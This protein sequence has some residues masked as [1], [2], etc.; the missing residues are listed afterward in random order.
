MSNA[1]N[2]SWLTLFLSLSIFFSLL[3][4]FFNLH[5]HFLTLLGLSV[6]LCLFHFLSISQMLPSSTSS[7]VRPHRTLRSCV[8]LAPMSCLCAR[9]MPPLRL[10]HLLL[11]ADLYLPYLLSRTPTPC[12]TQGPSPVSKACLFLSLPRAR[13]GLPLHVFP[14]HSHSRPHC[15]VTCQGSGT[16][17]SWRSSQRT[18]GDYR[19]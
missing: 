19:R 17:V 9:T 3:P 12:P 4:V 2:S 7:T 18:R 11:P 10:P 6:L 1:N 16:A 15:G 8:S 14:S 5:F 13:A